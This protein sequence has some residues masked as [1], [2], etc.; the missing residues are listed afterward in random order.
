MTESFA[1]CFASHKRLLVT[2]IGFVLDRRGRSLPSRYVARRTR[3]EK[4]GVLSQARGK[5]GRAI[6]VAVSRSPRQPMLPTSPYHLTFN[7][8]MTAPTL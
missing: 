1:L 2:F 3:A 5:K 8:A 7:E 4:G 6:R